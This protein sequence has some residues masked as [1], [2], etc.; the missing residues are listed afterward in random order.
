M[1][2]VYAV[3]PAVT[4]TNGLHTERSVDVLI[5]VS[6]AIR[7]GFC[8]ELRDICCS[9]V[10]MHTMSLY[11][12]TDVQAVREA[13][14]AVEQATK[15]KVTKQ[16]ALRDCSSRVQELIGDLNRLQQS[17]RELCMFPCTCLPM[18]STGQMPVSDSVALVF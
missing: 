2:T 5:R 9:A 10:C 4:A 14:A 12:I 18:Q 8:T 17:Q 15:F 11:V 13:D 16:H 3:S 7:T 1:H 6:V